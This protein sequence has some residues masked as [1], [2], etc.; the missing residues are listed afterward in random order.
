MVE[1]VKIQ[2]K[3]G[4]ARKNPQADVPERGQCI[5]HSLKRRGMFASGHDAQPIALVVAEGVD[6]RWADHQNVFN[7]EITES[8]GL[9]QQG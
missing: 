1:G 8:V 9:Q 3:R 4:A 7:I 5:P 6:S 2:P